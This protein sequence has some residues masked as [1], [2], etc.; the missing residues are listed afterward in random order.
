[1]GPHSPEGHATPKAEARV[2]VNQAAPCQYRFHAQIEKA[3]EISRLA[4]GG[5]A[6]AAAAKNVFNESV[7]LHS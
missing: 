4:R 1:M 3:R 7:A 6:L 5:P 2:D